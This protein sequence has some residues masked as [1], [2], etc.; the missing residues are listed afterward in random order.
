MCLT[1]LWALSQKLH[2]T[3]D[4]ARLLRTWS[5]VSTH[6]I[7]LLMR[8][9]VKIGYCP[10]SMM[11]CGGGVAPVLEYLNS[12]LTVS[13][14]LD[15]PNAN[16]SVNLISEMKFVALAQNQRYGTNALAPERVAEMATI[17]GACALGL[18]V[19]V[20][21]DDFDFALAGFREVDWAK[22]C[23]LSHWVTVVAPRQGPRSS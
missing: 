15:D 19:A 7:S 22:D 6:D 14:G 9:N 20:L 23:I 18:D 2:L 11:A 16:Q 12:G 5:T 10:A 4:T 21:H 1:S 13:I 3:N 17:G 8:C